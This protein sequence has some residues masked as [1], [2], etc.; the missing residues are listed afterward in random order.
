M[1][2]FNYNNKYEQKNE[3]LSLL[4]YEIFINKLFEIFRHLFF[5]PPSQ[6]QTLI[7]ILPKLVNSFLL[8][9]STSYR[10]LLL[11]NILVHSAS[12]LP[13]RFFR[14][15][16]LSSILMPIS[17][18]FDLF[19]LIC[20]KTILINFRIVIIIDYFIRIAYPCYFLKSTSILIKV[21]CLYSGSC[22]MIFNLTII[23]RPNSFINNYLFL[24]CI[25]A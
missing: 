23:L 11:K 16:I 5:L 18:N 17:V 12:I 14:L 6:N 8:F 21:Y 9:L 13:F 7:N 2:S 19:E 24:S 25:L 4:C 22:L 1:I 15:F 10:L 3:D 20:F